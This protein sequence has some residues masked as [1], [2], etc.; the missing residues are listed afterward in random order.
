MTTFVHNPKDY[1]EKIEEVYCFVS[2][3]EGGEG[4]V[5]HNF[6]GVMMPFVCADKARMEQLKPIAKEMAQMT[7]RKIKLIKLTHREELEDIS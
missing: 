1:L 6:G 7:G 2:V 4:V 5:G 3:D